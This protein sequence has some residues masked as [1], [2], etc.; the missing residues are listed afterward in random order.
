[1]KEKEREIC[2]N[3]YTDNSAALSAALPPWWVLVSGNALLLEP[4]MIAVDGGILRRQYSTF[5]TKY[6]QEWRGRNN[7]D[8]P[9]VLCGLSRLFVFQSIQFNLI[10][11]YCW[12]EWSARPSLPS[13][14]Q[15]DTAYHYNLFTLDPRGSLG[16][17]LCVIG[18][19]L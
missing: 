4:T 3:C 17:C 10:D 5:I 15:I 1:M 19:V 13:Y 14:N 16:L 9:W 11:I 8:R 18:K 2:S 6:P 7:N 12:L